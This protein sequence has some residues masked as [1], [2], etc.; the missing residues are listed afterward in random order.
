MAFKMVPVYTSS[1]LPG[2]T[3]QVEAVQ[4]AMMTRGVPPSTFPSPCTVSFSPGVV[5]AVF[6][7]KLHAAMNF[8]RITFEQTAR[9]YV[10]DWQLMN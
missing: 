9:Q 10:N 7:G 6:G 2:M 4:V 5:V 8:Q 1:V 3:S